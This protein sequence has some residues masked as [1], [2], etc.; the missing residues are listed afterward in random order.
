MFAAKA[1]E[2]ADEGAQFR[3]VLGDRLAGFH[4]HIEARLVV[5]LV[6]VAKLADAADQFL[7]PG[8]ASLHLLVNPGRGI[9]RSSPKYAT[10]V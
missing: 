5:D 2:R 1:G 6:T 9:L 4:R 7:H 8:E 10:N 3:E